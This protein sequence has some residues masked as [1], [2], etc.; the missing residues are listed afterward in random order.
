[1]LVHTRLSVLGETRMVVVETLWD[2]AKLGM[3]WKLQWRSGPYP[4][5]WDIL[6]EPYFILP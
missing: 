4:M 3:M 6:E 1:M 2:G 5:V